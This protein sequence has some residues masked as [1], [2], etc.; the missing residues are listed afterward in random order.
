MNLMEAVVAP[1]GITIPSSGLAFPVPA[2]YRSAAAR[3]GG[4]KG[5]AGF[6]PEAV[7]GPGT[8]PPPGAV[9]LRGV[10][11]M[12][13]PLGDEVIV[14]CRA[15]GSAL[16]LKVDPHCAPAP[17][18]TLDLHLSLAMLHLF[19]GESGARWSPEGP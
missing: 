3:L 11:E 5:V 15:G 16:A 7:S 19:D 18:A 2:A 14:H 6:R 4:R 12:L 10:V 1:D 9:R 13:E 8:P 17:G